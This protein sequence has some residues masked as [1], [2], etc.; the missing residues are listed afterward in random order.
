MILE[1]RQLPVVSTLDS[2]MSTPGQ[3]TQ[4]TEASAPNPSS[5]DNNSNANQ[6][7]SP[8][9]NSSPAQPATSSPASNN[10][11]SATQP[12][13]SAGETQPATNDASQASDN[14]SASE[15]AAPAPTS[16][17]ASPSSD[18]PSPSPTSSSRSTQAKPT[19]EAADASSTDGS[20]DRQS[21]TEVSE[22]SATEI[23]TSEVLST[24][25]TVTGSQGP[26]TSIVLVTAIRTQ[27]VPATE[28]SASATSTDDAAA[29][30]GS[31]SG[32]GGG[33]LS[34]KSKVAIGVAVPI[35]AIAILAL[36]G[37]FWWKKRKTRRQAEEERRKEVEDYAYNPNADPTIPAV[38]MADG[39]YEMR[40]DGSSGYRGW[41]NTTLGSTGRKAST[42][43]SGGVTGAY[44]DITSP[45]RGNMSDGRSGEPLMDGSHSPEGEILGAMGPS[46][47]NNRGADVHRGP[48]NASS[49][50]SA[51]G[52][53]DASDPMGVPYGA[54]NGYYDQYSQNPYSDNG[55]QQAVI[56]D[57]PARR[58]TRIENPSHYPQQSAGISQNF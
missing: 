42:T 26:E 54:G 15:T 12:S 2:A 33:G 41:G 51:A 31:G 24:I 21:T 45:T 55:P 38:G 19:T 6:P 17:N 20:N 32:N 35:A 50:Y 16:D 36:L 48:S 44:S 28:A 27:R 7:S 56:R 40:E 46:A 49:S 52:R 4:P 47:A 34:Q 58:N 43:L 3:G 11:P 14:A 37:L 22:A 9:E 1:H 57:N 23:T 13:P 18:D 8:A 5:V 25:V 53:S 29:I 10:N 39:G 30:G